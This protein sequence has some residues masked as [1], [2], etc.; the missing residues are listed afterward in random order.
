MAVQSTNMTEET[1][2]I[3]DAQKAG[4][5][6]A[7][8]E[9]PSG[10]PG[11]VYEGTTAELQKYHT[12]Q[13]LLGN[14]DTRTSTMSSGTGGMGGV[15]TL[16]APLQPTGQTTTQKTSYTG[17]APTNTPVFKAPEEW[18]PS[19][20]A[21]EQQ[22][23]SALGLRENRQ[24]LREAIAGLGNDPASR[25]ALRD[26]LNAHGINIE[27]TMLGAK[28]AAQQEESRQM[29][30]RMTVAQAE[31][32]NAQNAFENEWRKYLS[33]GETVSTAKKTYDTNSNETTG[34]NGIYFRSVGK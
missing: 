21:G 6:D 1:D 26:A 22:A 14:V 24:A 3:K 17:K 15:T 18:T 12:R 32:T 4:T 34:G 20:R 11:S 30:Q 8:R 10:H 27:R 28:T 23:Q 19:Q 9:Y 33:T 13:A 31:Y 25:L 2:A 5:W 16:S 29:N 7:S